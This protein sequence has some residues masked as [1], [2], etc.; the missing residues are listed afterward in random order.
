MPKS[1]P[2]FND[3][4][5]NESDL[6]A[7]MANAY[8]GRTA[9]AKFDN[10]D[11]DHGDLLRDHLGGNGENPS[12]SRLRNDSVSSDGDG[13]GG[14]GYLG[15]KDE[16]VWSEATSGR[17]ADFLYGGRGESTENVGRRVS[18]SGKQS[19]SPLNKKLLGEDD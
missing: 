6:D 16:R 5:E 18:S 8:G 10:L 14:Y 17:G 15:G 3:D 1:R 19:T 7:G 9:T 11:G 13:G 12:K 2:N 4:Y